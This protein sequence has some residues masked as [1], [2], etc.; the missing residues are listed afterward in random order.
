MHV[1][2]CIRVYVC[3]F[4]CVCVCVCV[5]A[6]CALSIICHLTNS[7]IIICLRQMQVYLDLDQ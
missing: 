7:P 5:C 2:V 3:V 4:V 1:S 6:R